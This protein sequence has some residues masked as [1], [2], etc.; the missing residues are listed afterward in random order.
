MVEHTIRHI[1]L[2]SEAG[3]VI[4]RYD[5]SLQPLLASFD[6]ATTTTSKA[7]VPMIVQA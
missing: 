1:L 7:L 5:W 2:N 4:S 3:D 6:L